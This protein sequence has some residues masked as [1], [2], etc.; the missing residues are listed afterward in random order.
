M[1]RIEGNQWLDCSLTSVCAICCI[2]CNPI[3]EGESIIYVNPTSSAR[4]THRESKDRESL[5]KTE[6]VEGQQ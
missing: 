4:H 6:A 5:R 2:V 1:T 3:K